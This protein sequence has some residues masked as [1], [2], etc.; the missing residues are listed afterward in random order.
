MILLQT[1]V[2][3]TESVVLTGLTPYTEYTLSVRCRS[4]HGGFWSESETQVVRTT[5]SGE[6][7]SKI[8]RFLKK[9]VEEN[10]FVVQKG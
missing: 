3:Q 5:P 4:V 6:D 2:V 7:G 10:W 1:K 8:V 9:Q